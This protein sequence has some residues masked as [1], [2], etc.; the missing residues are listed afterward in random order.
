MIIKI[1][2]LIFLTFLVILI[3][4]FIV[5]KIPLPKEQKTQILTGPTLTNEEKILNS[6][7][8]GQKVG[9]LFLIGFEGK[10]L[11]PEL[12][13][14]IKTIHPGGVLL[15]SR[16]IENETQFK[17]LIEDLQKISLEDNG[18]L[19]F[20]AVDQEG[21]PMSRIKWL[22]EKTSQSVIQN[23][24]QAYEVGFNRGKELKKLGINL[25][26]APVLDITIPADFLYNRSFQKN[27]EETAKLAK[28]LISGQ[29]VAGIL[30][31]VKHFPGYGGIIFNP[32]RTKLPVL[33]KI[34]EIS[35]F[36]EVLEVQPEMIMVANVVYNEIDE[37]FPFA[38][39]IKGI[40]FLKEELK[41]N[42]LIISDDISSPVLKKELSLKNTV[43]LAFQSGI[44]IL[45]I[46]GFDEPEDPFLAFNFL[47]EAARKNEIS[48]DK[49]NQSV[50][51]IIQL[52]QNLL[53]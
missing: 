40:Q 29:K 18:L 46:A 41:N 15:L 33:F 34:P 6:L 43:I 39:S 3:F 38:L 25:N 35:Q 44:N 36:K 17:K 7:T 50:L 9:Q 47:L 28:A 4:S 22:S 16:N 26:L 31:A 5:H 52:K 13:N 1:L 48:E 37:K 45:I 23:T 24:E 12:E 10:I 30:T 49:I 51:K 11:T 32:E 53:Y 19:L 14:I 42:F 8:L 2:K 20:I 21:E 27:P